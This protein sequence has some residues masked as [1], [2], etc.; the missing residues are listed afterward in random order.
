VA[1]KLAEQGLL[2]LAIPA[3]KGGQ[4]WGSL[5]DVPCSVLTEQ[6]TGTLTVRP[7]SRTFSFSAPV[8]MTCCSRIRKPVV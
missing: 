1:R 4:G 5:R 8:H 6:G 3:K 2:G 7:P